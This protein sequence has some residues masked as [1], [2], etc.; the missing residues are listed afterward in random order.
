[1]ELKRYLD[2]IPIDSRERLASDCQTS[3]A[4]L[5]NVSYGDKTCSAILAALIEVHSGGAVKRWGLR[6]DDWHL[7]WPELIETDGAPICKWTV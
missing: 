2:S 5:R 1:M 7:I 3:W 6:P 4:H